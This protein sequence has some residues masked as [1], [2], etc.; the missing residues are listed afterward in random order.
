[1]KRPLISRPLVGI[2]L[3]ITMII[4]PARSL[5]GQDDPGTIPTIR[6]T[7]T[8]APEPTP[9]L[10][11]QLVPNYWERQPG[12]AAQFY[13]RAVLTQ[14]SISREAMDNF[15]Q[16]LDAWLEWPL[17]DA[18]KQEIK[19]YLGLYG[20]ALEQLRTAIYREHCDWD[21]RLKDLK[22][23][24]VVYFILEEVQESRNLAQM[25]RLKARV[26]IAEGRYDNALRD[27]A[28]RLATGARRRTDSVDR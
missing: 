5:L 10:R 20:G 18:H 19:E 17:T 12:N 21:Y 23:E 14:K 22:G 27:P 1:M 24:A 13:Y 8:P 7:L 4:A 15:R 16:K 11:Y 28:N 9:A 3:A 25:L 2:V 26:E 6:I